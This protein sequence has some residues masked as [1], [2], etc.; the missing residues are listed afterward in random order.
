MEKKIVTY[1][2]KFVFPG[3]VEKEFPVNID[4]NSLDLPQEKKEKLPA[5]TALGVSRCRNCSL[6]EKKY[7]HCPVAVSI[8]DLIETFKYS[9]SYEKV[10]VFIDDGVRQYFKHT[11]HED[12]ISSLMGLSMATCGCPVMSRLRPVARF[13]LPFA[14]GEETKFRVLGAYLSGQ[15]FRMK[16]GLEPDWTLKG[17]ASLYNDIRVV[18]K[19]FSERLM[20]ASKSDASINALVRLDC[21]AMQVSFLLDQNSLGVLEPLFE[22][23]L[24]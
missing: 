15:Y 7:S 17:L 11:T 14:T 3:G 4:E 21:F 13:H 22:P 23:Y 19:A 24:K 2:Y 10:D 6:D 16:A 1:R 12:A 18:N 9:I 8:A 20:N 5:W